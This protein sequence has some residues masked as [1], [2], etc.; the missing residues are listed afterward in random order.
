MRKK[1][2]VSVIYPKSPCLSCPRQ[3]PAGNVLDELPI[4]SN[5]FA[6]L[7]GFLYGWS[8]V[9]R[10]CIQDAL[11][12]VWSRGLVQH[13]IS[14]AYTAPRV[15]RYGLMT[16][17][18]RHATFLVHTPNWVRASKPA[19]RRSFSVPGRLEAL[20]NLWER[21]ANTVHGVEASHKK[22]VLCCGLSHA[23]WF[24]TGMVD[25]NKRKPGF[26]SKEVCED[27]LPFFLD[28]LDGD[29]YCLR[30]VFVFGF[31]VCV[32]GCCAFLFRLCLLVFFLFL[33]LV[34]LFRCF[35]SCCALFCLVV[36]LLPFAPCLCVL[37]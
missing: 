34:W 27:L 6:F 18:L 16:P 13:F 20:T 21:T 26:F 23:P 3:P 14:A 30:F 12:F 8:D 28:F 15:L 29:K 19:F 11:L 31:F 32:C 24:G 22:E 33:L 17:Q 4:Q 1:S 37:V 25:S 2:L 5:P 36:L 7:L 10:R 9:E 35:C